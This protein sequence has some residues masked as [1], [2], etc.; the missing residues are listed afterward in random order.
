MSLLYRQK[1]E[2]VAFIL[3]NDKWEYCRVRMHRIMTEAVLMSVQC[4]LQT[5]LCILKNIHRKTMSKIMLWIRQC[6]WYA[7]AQY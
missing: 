5:V 6:L 7:H 1:W 4:W 3:I 2:I